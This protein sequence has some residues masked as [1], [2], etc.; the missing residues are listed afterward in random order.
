[1]ER[2]GGDYIR[3][4]LVAWCIFQNGG[5]ADMICYNVNCLE[6]YT[7]LYSILSNIL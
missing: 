5:E 3:S 6:V 2:S 4:C 7:S 1:M